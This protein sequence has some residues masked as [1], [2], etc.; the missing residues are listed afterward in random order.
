MTTDGKRLYWRLRQL[1]T[2]R[3]HEGV[4]ELSFASQINRSTLYPI[5]QGKAKGISLRI[6]GT[7]CQTLDA[8]PGGWFRWEGDELVW[9]VKEVAAAKGMTRQQLVWS[10]E[11]LPHSLA[12]IWRGE[13][14]FV[15]VDTLEKLAR[16]LEL[17]VG[18]LFAWMTPDEFAAE[19][20]AAALEKDQVAEGAVV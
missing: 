12:P 3:G 4:R 18:D 7:L 17:D 10:A 14:Q 2:Q 5:W 16:A 9:N 6:L 11:I 13:Q 15:F 20:A 19:E 1:A 8:H